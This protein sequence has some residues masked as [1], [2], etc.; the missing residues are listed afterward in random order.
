[1]S[2]NRKRLLLRHFGSIERLRQ[3]TAAEIAE[4]EGVGPKLAETLV[5]FFA[6]L[7]RRG[8]PAEGEPPE[9][10]T[11]EELAPEIEHAAGRELAGENEVVYHLKPAP[12]DDSLPRRLPTAR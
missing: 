8:A 3:A 5:D 10:E 7:K 12:A 11:V 2:E 4:V 9:G 6:R 1:V